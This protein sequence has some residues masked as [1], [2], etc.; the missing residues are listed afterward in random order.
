MSS[1]RPRRNMTAQSVA[2]NITFRR[3]KNFPPNGRS[4][5]HYNS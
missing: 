5:G 3:Q 1:S 2:S 4:V